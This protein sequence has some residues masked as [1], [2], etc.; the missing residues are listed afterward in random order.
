MNIIKRFKSLPVSSRRLLSLGMVLGLFVGLPLFIWAIVTQRFLISQKAQ[1]V[2]TIPLNIQE[3]FTG[4][5]AIDTTKWN[6]SGYA[7]NLVSLENDKLKVK[8]PHGSF[9]PGNRIEGFNTVVAALVNSQIPYVTGPF[10]VSVDVASIEPSTSS[11]SAGLKFA[12]G[13]GIIIQRDAGSNQ[14]QVLE[15][16]TNTIYSVVSAF[17][18][19]QGTT[20]VRLRLL[21]TDQDVQA[22]YDIGAGY[23]LLKTFTD[24]GYVSAVDTLPRLIVQTEPPD[25]PIGTVFFDNYSATANLIVPT[26]SP[27]PTESPTA[28]PEQTSTPSPTAFATETARP[29]ASPAPTPPPTV[30]PFQMLFKFDG[31]TDD[32]ASFERLATAAAKVTVKFLSQS[33]GYTQGWVTTPIYVTY[34]GAGIYK[35]RFGVWSA[36]LPAANDYAITLKGEKHL[37]VK[38][39]QPTGQTAHCTGPGSISMPVDPNTP[40]NYDF[41]G[42]PLPAGDLYPQDGTVTTVGENSD[43]SRMLLLLAKPPSELTAQDLLVGDLDYNQVINIRD[44]YLFR[45]TL[46]T[47]YDEN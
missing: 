43:L 24:Q 12:P 3:S 20:S 9:N 46:Q 18:L 32:G 11:V 26:P 47:R 39:C 13:S 8:V 16:L 2:T 19:P 6:W 44:L 15:S 41:T 42:I 17:S 5:G 35:L 23:V 14:I 33:L 40:N 45:K 34:D 4:T 28:I 37:S 38:F 1:V 25:F 21:R 30:R 36:N 22:F 10:D 31:V 29:T 7:E 27:S